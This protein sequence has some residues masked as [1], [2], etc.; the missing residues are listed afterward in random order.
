MESIQNWATMV[1]TGTVICGLFAKL[2]PENSCGKAS[3]TL[4]SLFFV[5]LL[6]EP[7]G[8]LQ[9]FELK[10]PELYEETQFYTEDIISTSDE[11]AY[12]LAE[13]HILELIQDEL[14]KEGFTAE[15]LRLRFEEDEV[16]LTLSLPI[17]YAEREGEMRQLLKVKCGVTVE[18][19][20]W[21]R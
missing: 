18:N 3:K 21:Q 14:G 6:L 17:S 20:D 4:L 5:C 10:L 7:L 2:L 16:F 1:C 8:T 13:T 15:N 12:S 9:D 19:I 11:L